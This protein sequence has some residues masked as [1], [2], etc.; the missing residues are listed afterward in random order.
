MYHT[1]YKFFPKY[2]RHFIVQRSVATYH[3]QYSKARIKQQYYG[4]IVIWDLYNIL[5]TQFFCNTVPKEYVKIM[6]L[7]Y[8]NDS[9]YISDI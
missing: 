8:K 9:S 4:G 7:Y 3:F 2:T 1:N 5:K 6:I